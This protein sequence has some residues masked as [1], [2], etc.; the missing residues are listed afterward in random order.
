MEEYFQEACK[1]FK[2]YMQND[3]AWKIAIIT[4]QVYLIDDFWA[5]I[6]LFNELGLK[7]IHAYALV[8][9]KELFIEEM[10]KIISN[11]KMSQYE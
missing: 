2:V 7:K 8:N 4:A 11:N 9:D 6:E 10:D 5:A 1:K 3:N